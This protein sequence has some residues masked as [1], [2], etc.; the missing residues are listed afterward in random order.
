M[1]LVNHNATIGSKGL[2]V[3]ISTSKTK[4]VRDHQ[5]SL[6]TIPWPLQSLLD[7]YDTQTQPQPAD[8][9]NVNREAVSKRLKAIGKIQ[10][11]GKWVQHEHELNERLM[12]NR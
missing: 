10:R 1:P 11:V 7:E 2:N 12:D 5:K 4:N 6:R 8:Q 9:L 3:E